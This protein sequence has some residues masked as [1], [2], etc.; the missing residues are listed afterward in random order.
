MRMIK[1]FNDFINEELS[2]LTIYNTAQ[3]L[4]EKGHKNRY[5]NLKNISNIFYTSKKYD[6]YNI[7][8]RYD[9]KRVIREVTND[10]YDDFV[11]EFILSSPQDD[12][13]KYYPLTFSLIYLSTGED[14]MEGNVGELDYLSLGVQFEINNAQ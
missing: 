7:S 9:I 1:V 6:T 11:Q 8:N 10:E 14:L 2:P 3:K 5:I 4:K 13:L 12:I